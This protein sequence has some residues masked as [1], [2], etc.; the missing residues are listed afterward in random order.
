V[1]S[2]RVLVVPA[3]GQGRGGGHLARS[4]ALVRDLR[5]VGRE[6]FL[7]LPESSDKSHVREMLE[8]IGLDDT[9]WILQGPSQ[10]PRTKEQSEEAWGFVVLD[11][12]R[13]TE[14]EAASWSALA[15]LVGIDEGGPGRNRFDFLIDLLP[16]PPKR[17][18]GHP[19]IA[20][21]SLLPL[22][23]NRRS[24]FH[25]SSGGP[26]RVLVSFGAEDAAGLGFPAAMALAKKA[27]QDK[28]AITLIAPSLSEDQARELGDLRVTVSKGRP[29]LREHLAEYDLLVTHF[30]L[31]AFEAL[32]ARLPAILASP[33]SYHEKLARNAGF[34]SLGIG[35]A[36]AGSIGRRLFSRKDG[37]LNADFIRSLADTCEAMA[38][39]YGLD[40]VPERN[41]GD[42]L[43]SFAPQVSRQC[44]VCGAPFSGS[45]TGRQIP[46]RFPDRT[47]R[48]C[49]RCGI[50]H[51]IRSSP[52]Q[53][54]YETDYFFGRYKKQYGKT[55][56]EDLP[57][58]VKVGMQRLSII[59][60]LLGDSHLLGRNLLDIGCAYGPFLIAASRSGFSPLGIDPAG[61]AVA[62]VRDELGIAAH[63]GFFPDISS[64]IPLREKSFEV[65]TLWYVIEHF[66]D[67]GRVL[68]EVNRLLAVR[69]VLAFSTPSFSG[70][71]GRKSLKAFLESSPQDHWT[72]WNP[73][74]CGRILARYGFAL[75]KIRVTGIHPERFPLGGGLRRGGLLWRLLQCVSRIFRL[76]DTFECYAVK[77]GDI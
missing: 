21:P 71:S 42:L 35:P 24:G 30:G 77:T 18:F 3:T 10:D 44:P 22:P 20:A 19:N 76:G 47:Y 15:P 16:T 1:N 38:A 69:G 40:A 43:A 46:G 45:G 13:T 50:I 28:L 9:P 48:R 67:I 17:G 34:L 36:A 73:A 63:E 49:G 65:L 55:Y 52:P 72:V 26:L 75:K 59:R 62:Y 68:G 60:H 56:L 66:T 6:A 8:I 58:L 23:T 37:G 5:A 25:A 74:I 11:N 64:Q 27:Q 31:G 54:E 39:R 41:L 2:A 61:D 57:N 12:F 53:I 51:M 33:G 14:G 70:I 4:A 7:F 32:H 29:E